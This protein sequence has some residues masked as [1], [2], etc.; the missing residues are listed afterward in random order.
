ME[1]GEDL[2]TRS[3]AKNENFWLVHVENSLGFY[4]ACLHIS[5][6]IWVELLTLLGTNMP[7]LFEDD[8]PFPQVGYIILLL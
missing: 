3:P 4:I 7:A 8:D 5:I 2:Y 6:S 1:N